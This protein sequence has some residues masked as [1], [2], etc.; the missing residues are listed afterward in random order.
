MQRHAASYVCNDYHSGTP[1]CVTKMI[2]NLNWE[3]LE[4]RRRHERFGML[5][6]IQYNLVDI[7]TDRY[8]QVSDSHT[9]G[10]AKFYKE[11]ISD[12]TYS[13]SF[14]PSTVPHSNKLPVDIVPAASLEE[15]T[16]LLC[17]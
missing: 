2:D 14:F 7:R 3:P 16:S 13:N 11:L 5:Y 6:R 15:F 10:P 1:G 9:R 12:V 17:V 4:V 8:L